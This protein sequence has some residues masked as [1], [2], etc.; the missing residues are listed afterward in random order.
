MLDRLLELLG[1]G[2]T[3]PIRSLADELDTTPELVRAMVEDLARMGYLRRLS[4]ECEAGCSSCSLS[5]MC[6]ARGAPREDG[7]RQGM[8]GW[9]LVDTRRAR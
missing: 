6:V 7:G 5:G 3:R 2:G 1:E 9:A 8:T 4:A